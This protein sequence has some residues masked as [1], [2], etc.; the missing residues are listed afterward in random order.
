M[1][2][3]LSHQILKLLLRRLLN[4]HREYS[5]FQ[6]LSCFNLTCHQHCPC[7]RPEVLCMGMLTFA[8]SAWV[9]NNEID[10]LKGRQCCLESK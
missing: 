3:P 9:S 5:A 10:P 8:H 6:H 2:Q 7:M 4:L 1:L